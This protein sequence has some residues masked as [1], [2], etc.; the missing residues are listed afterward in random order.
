VKTADQPSR[1]ICLLVI[2]LLTFFLEGCIGVKYIPPATAE[3]PK[4]QLIHLS[5]LNASKYII[6]NINGVVVDEPAFGGSHRPYDFYVLPGTYPVDFT[7]TSGFLVPVPIMGFAAII[8]T[9]AGSTTVTFTSDHLGQ[10]VTFKGLLREAG[11]IQ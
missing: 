7:E 8:K 11:A 5:Q 4:A 2:S 1:R 3:T 10:T 9:N 6:R